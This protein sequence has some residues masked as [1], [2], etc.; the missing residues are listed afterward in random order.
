MSKQRI[1][2]LRRLLRQYN[3]EYHVLDA[4]SVSDQ[5]YDR[6]M[7]ELIA[8]EQAYPEYFDANSPTQKVGGLVLDAFQKVKHKHLMLSLGNVYNE[9][10]VKDFITKI[11]TETHTHEFVVELKIDGLAMSAH[12][13]N[14]QFIQAVTRGDGEVGEDVSVNVRT[15]RSIPLDIHY[16]EDIEI[17]GEV[18]LPKAEFN[19]INREKEEKGEDLFANPR[20]AAAGSIRQLDSKIA[21]SRKLEAF[22]YYL[23]DA[24]QKGLK[25]HSEA[26][27]WMAK[28]GFKV[29]PYT[30]VCKGA[31]EVWD[32]IVDLGQHRPDLPYEIDGI[33]IKVNDF[34]VQ[35]NLGFT[36][37]TPRW[38]V[39][40]KFPAEEV[41]T[42]LNDIFITVGRTGKITPNAALAPVR[43][44]GT[45][46][47][48]AQ[49]HNEDFIRDKD[50]RIGDIVTVRKAGEIIPEVVMSHPERRDGTQ[51]PYVFPSEC[52]ACGGPLIRIQDEAHHRCINTQCSA[53]LVESLAHYASRDALNIDGLGIKSI[54]QL[55]EAGLVHTLLDLYHLMSQRTQL[56]ELPGWKEKSVDKLFTSIELSK[57]QPLEKLLTGLGIT[58]VGEKAAQ[59][60]AQHFKTMD[61][62]MQAQLS[63]L[64]QIQDVGPITAQ[65]ILDYFAEE[66][67]KALIEGL[68]HEGVRMDTTL[69][70]TQESR[71][72]GLT[73][74]VTGSI[75]G[76][77]R[78]EAQAWLVAHGAKVSGSVSSKTDVVIYGEAA[79]SKLDK[80][81]ELGIKT[82]SA[83]EFLKEVNA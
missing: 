54:E 77:S 29:N 39:A 9:Q 79:G 80:A 70:Q 82:L 25:T 21:A 20:N 3:Q 43:I 68:K 32:A 83:D 31:Q 78:D 40:Y 37:K 48:F 10:E 72:S 66:H 33:V 67:N 60:L 69:I 57:T 12:F 5:E 65:S 7:Q 19:R 24:D 63:D 49:L 76:M 58:Q 8:L 16:E 22:W 4:P 28:Q 71:F 15:I 34:S 2:H 51:V 36:A 23:V 62:L 81:H 59:V 46:V 26:L 53:R 1:D 13:E 55:Y 64:S 18:Y 61:A 27:A 73:V 50:I 45:T 35:R 41:L 6:C 42:T 47:S 30:K 75:E 17:R 52:P 74:V 38:A 14:G 56:L 44:A 11:E